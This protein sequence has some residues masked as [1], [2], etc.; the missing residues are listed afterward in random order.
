M[1]KHTLTFLIIIS[2]AKIA[3]AYQLPNNLQREIINTYFRDMTSDGIE[4]ITI[5]NKDYYCVISSTLNFNDESNFEIQR[6]LECVGKSLLFQHLKKNAPNMKSLR[7]KEWFNGIMWSQKNLICMFCYIEKKN[8]QPI[9]LQN[10]PENKKTQS[11]Y[12]K[13]NMEEDYISITNA[14]KTIDF[15]IEKLKNVIRIDPKDLNAYKELY[16]FYYAN[17]NLKEAN[18]TIDKIMDLKFLLGN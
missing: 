2:L 6:E 7:V 5:G 4:E 9:I 11:D 1:L 12:S 18:I 10:E 13:T 14:K 17:G 3:F 8:L 16:K 15:E